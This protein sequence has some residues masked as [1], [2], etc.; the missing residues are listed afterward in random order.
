M[1]H[2]GEG[3]GHSK[4]QDRLQGDKLPGNVRQQNPRTEPESEE[5]ESSTSE[6]ESES[7]S[8]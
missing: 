7:E 2:K 6:S 3:Q 5:K 4:G 8:E 1:H